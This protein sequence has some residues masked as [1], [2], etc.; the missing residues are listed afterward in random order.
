MIRMQA[1]RQLT[2]STR[3]TVHY[4]L[5]WPALSSFSPYT[6]RWLVSWLLQLIAIT[7]FWQNNTVAMLSPSLSVSRLIQ[8]NG[9]EVY[10]Q[11]PT[12]D[13]FV[14]IFVRLLLILCLINCSFS[15]TSRGSIWAILVIYNMTSNNTN[16][17]LAINRLWC[18]AVCSA[19]SSRRHC[20]VE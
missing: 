2:V 14:R 8:D 12:C 20:S 6:H 19:A 5:D 16:N 13:I 10:T 11:S 9:T 3:C 4:A 17:T 7:T 15:V 1:R 18:A